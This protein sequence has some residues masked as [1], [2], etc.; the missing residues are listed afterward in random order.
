MQAGAHSLYMCVHGYLSLCACM[1][2]S[3]YVSVPVHAEAFIF[4]LCHVV[5]QKVN[6]TSVHAAHS[7]QSWLPLP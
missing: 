3:V 5:S 1:E 6:M 4:A 2:V 7:S